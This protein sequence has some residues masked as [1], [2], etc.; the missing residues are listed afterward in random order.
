MTNLEEPTAR[1]GVRVLVADGQSDV[2]IVMAKAL[3]EAGYEVVEIRDVGEARALT[4][5]PAGLALVV[6]DVD[7]PGFDGFDVANH[8]RA[9]DPDVPILFVTDEPDRVTDRVTREP[10]YCLSKPF[11]ASVLLEVTARLLA[12]RRR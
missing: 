6:T 7:I 12:V 10:C 11:N 8:A 4:E 5:D 9:R 2:R 1:A 3:R